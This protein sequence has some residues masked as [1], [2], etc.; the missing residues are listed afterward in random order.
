MLYDL[1][2]N[3]SKKKEIDLCKIYISFIYLSNEYLKMKI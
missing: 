2:K 3:H 1:K